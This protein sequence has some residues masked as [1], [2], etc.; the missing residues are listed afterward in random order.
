MNCLICDVTL[1]NNKSLAGHLRYHHVDYNIKRYY[2]AFIKK[3]ENDGICHLID[4]NNKTNFNGMNHGYLK[5]CCNSHAQKSEDTLKKTKRTREE[6]YGNEKYTN[7]KLARKTC[8][9]KYNDEFYNNRPKCATSLLSRNE[10]EKELWRERVRNTWMNKNME[11][12]ELIYSTRKRTMLSKYG[13]INNIEKQKNTIL[14]K[15]GVTNISQIK[16]VKEKVQNFWKTID[17]ET[18]NR[19][20]EN[21]KNTFLSKYGV[22]HNMHI[23]EICSIVSKKSRETR[24]RLGQIL[25]ESEISEFKKYYHIVYNETKKT[26]KKHFTFNEL[27]DRGKCG[28]DGAIQIDHIFSIKEGFIN[29]IDPKI[30]GHKENLRLIPWKE[31]DNKKSRCDITLNELLVKKESG[32]TTRLNG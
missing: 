32:T 27:I 10:E 7:R 22:E 31:N 12:L 19:I 29:N 30:I 1:K 15:Y 14:E 6:R 16:E 18:L 28:I 3:D 25:P 11:E 4:C 9:E 24:E 2:D 17:D 20:N 23:P 8:Q 13:N 26:I 5:Y 21:R